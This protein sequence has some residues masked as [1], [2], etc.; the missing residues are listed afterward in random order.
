MDDDPYQ[1]FTVK[2]TLEDSGDEYEVI[3]ADS[4]RQCLELL[5]N[6]ELP[7]LILLD[8][9]M[10]EMSGWEAFKKIKENPLWKKIPI[11]FIPYFLK[12]FCKAI[13]LSKEITSFKL[14]SFRSIFFIKNSNH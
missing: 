8:I 3:R 7:D 5:R 13:L 9:M 11:V 2:K 4:G 1:T 10:P 14:R 6:N 12:S